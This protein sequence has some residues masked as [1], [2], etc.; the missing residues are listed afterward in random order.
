MDRFILRLGAGISLGFLAIVIMMVFEVVARYG[1][2]AP[3]IWAHE[4]AGIFAAVAFLIGGAYCMVDKS[5]MRITL[6][7]D[8]ASPGFRRLAEFIGLVCG[9]VYIGGL[10]YSAW[11][12]TERSLLRFQPDGT[13][14]PETSGTSWNTP[15]P[16]FIK[17]ALFISCA[18]FLAVLLRQLWRFFRR[19][20][21]QASDGDRV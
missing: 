12:L 21:R 11:R 5:H 20:N 10:T 4:I 14:I 7:S 2:N 13:W 16:A 6:L 3:T 17:A 8:A 18:L 1:F 19:P 15:M 9:L